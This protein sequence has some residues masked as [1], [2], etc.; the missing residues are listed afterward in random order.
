MSSQ[1]P[2]VHELDLYRDSSL[3]HPIQLHLQGCSRCQ[4][5]LLALDAFVAGEDFP[6][7]EN[8][9]SL[10]PGNLAQA[11]QKL[12]T[13]I[14]DLT[15]QRRQ[16]RV[17]RWVLS[18]AAVLVA[19]LGLWAVGPGLHDSSLDL[20]PVM[21][22]DTPVFSTEPMT[23][24][25]VNLHH[26]GDLQLTWN[27]A[28]GATHYQV[29]FWSSDLME[30]SRLPQVK[31]PSLLIR[32]QDLPDKKTSSLFSILAFRQEEEILRS[33]VTGLDRN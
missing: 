4:A 13:F 6:A 12:K 20:S 32:A 7:D 31:K 26:N 2:E 25:T 9:E 1:C 28:S 33:K 16:A 30:T 10:S 29:V 3:D 22:G 23:L 19:A 21:R 15:P 8:Q 17:P 5:S 14:D 18:M 11:D 27:P 24:T